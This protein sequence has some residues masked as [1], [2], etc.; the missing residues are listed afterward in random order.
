M[1]V[2]SNWSKHLMLKSRKA[3][4]F[5]LMLVFILAAFEC[6]F[7]FTGKV[8]QSRWAMWMP[9]GNPTAA[10]SVLSYEQYLKVRDP[11][12]GWPY[13]RQ[14]GDDL[15]VN[16]AQRNPHFPNGP[17]EGSCVSLYGDSFTEG[18]DT[19]SREKNWGN[20]LSDRLGCYVANFGFGGYGTDQAYLRF[21]ENRSD[22]SPVVI[23]GLHTEDVLRNL[24]RVR[25]LQNFSK[26][27]A[28]KPRFILDDR[29]ELK[30]IPIPTLTEQEYLRIVG[31]AGDP[32]VLEYEDFQPGGAAGVVKLEFP[33]TVS[34]VKNMLRFHGFRSRLLGRPEWM[35]F[36]QRG[37]AVHGLEITGGITGKFVELA[38]QRG[39]SPFVVILP[40]PLDFKYFQKKG[41]WPYQTLIEDYTQ[42]SIPFVDFGPYLLSIAQ[43]QKKE[44]AQYIGPTGHYNDE[45]N[46]LVA[47][48]VYDRMTE[49]GL[50][51]SKR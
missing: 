30:L 3:V 42:K 31:L 33:Y 44:I 1:L 47:R 8:L 17:K 16:G 12:L 32:L 50:L 28:L 10:K 18:G 14:Y 2:E 39:K 49:R 19:S 35:E 20:L 23:F 6:L 38:R 36:L 4:F 45:G 41:S 40:H 11:I 9:P 51:P 46:A 37:N 25:D 7:F 22:P 26:W 5:A 15:D 13:P 21:A 34:V 27:Y 48:F 29:G 43:E 24:T